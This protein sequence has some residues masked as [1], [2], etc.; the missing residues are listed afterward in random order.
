[1]SV[2]HNVFCAFVKTT[3]HERICGCCYRGTCVA[4]Y[5][6]DGR[7]SV[8]RIPWVLGSSVKGMPVVTRL[9]YF[10]V[11]LWEHQLGSH[12]QCSLPREAADR[13]ATPLPRPAVAEALVTYRSEVLA[14][15][16]ASE[17][18]GC[19]P[20]CRVRSPR[21]LPRRHDHRFLETSSG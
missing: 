21:L 15:T 11:Q 13:L 4:S 2:H 20:L 5:C 19:T 14:A 8:F 9:A 17:D 3:T 10:A 1:M 18:K 12:S 7:C 6:Q 16:E